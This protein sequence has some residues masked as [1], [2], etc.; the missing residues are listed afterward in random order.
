[1][2]FQLDPRTGD[3]I[4]LPGSTCFF[5][6]DGEGASGEGGD[7][8]GGAG[9]GEGT[10]DGEGTGSENWYDDISD[11]AMRDFA[12]RYT[13]RDEAI[14]AG[15]TFRQ[16]LSDRSPSTINAE[17]SEDD[18]AAFRQAVGTPE[19]AAGYEITEPEGY[20]R[21]EA[22]S[23]FYA[24]MQEAAHNASLAPWQWAQLNAAYTGFVEATQAAQP[25]VIETGLEELKKEWGGDYDTNVLWAGQGAKKFGDADFFNFIRTTEVNGVPIGDHPSFLKT[26]AAIG[27]G[28]AENPTEVFPVTEES[29]QTMQE[30]LT[31]LSAKQADALQAG[32]HDEA[33]R[34]QTEIDKITRAMTGGQPIV[35]SQGRAA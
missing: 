34:R 19:E 5:D 32:N 30:Q 4:W 20:E 7:G 21:T 35:G 12:A 15:L 25:Q 33:E 22:D 10:G 14:K 3:W 28:L 2:S 17:S 31:D 29:Q 8:S 18:V 26:F 1:M 9:E 27:R 6:G 13:T 16:Q 24:G 23:Q 11:E